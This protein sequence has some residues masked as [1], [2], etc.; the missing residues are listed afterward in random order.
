MLESFLDTSMLDDDNNLERICSQGF[1]FPEHGLVFPVGSIPFNLKKNKGYEILVCKVG[2]GKS[3]C[4]SADQHKNQQMKL[5]KGFDSLYIYNSPDGD[6]KNPRQFKNDYMI[7][8]NAQVLPSYVI[9]FE[10]DFDKEERMRIP[11]CDICHET[12]A[13]FYCKSDDACLCADCDDDFHN[14]GGTLTAKHQRVPVSERPKS[15]G[16]CGAHPDNTLEYYCQVCSVTLCV[17]CKIS[18]SHS[19][20]EAT[21]HPLIRL[22]DAY[23]KSLQ[24]AKEIDPE[25]EKK[26]TLLKTL[27][28]EIDSRIK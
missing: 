25:L 11:L 4:I 12:P 20:G 16:Q 17:Y 1:N 3:Y 5:P 22:S 10:L 7:Y 18:G 26:K 14:K 23:Q 19:T 6:A 28:K 2:V 13:V 24:Q 8:D 15:L 21:S 27:L 9:H